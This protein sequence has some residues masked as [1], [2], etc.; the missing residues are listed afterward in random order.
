MSADNWTQCP[1]CY[2]KNMKRAN[3]LDKIAAES[4][5]KVSVDKFDEL[6]NEAFSFRKAIT[7]DE[8]I[9]ETLR[10]DYSI[11][12]QDGEFSVGYCG[13]CD[14][15]GFKFEYKHKEEVQ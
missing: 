11:G 13:R 2:E 6:R 10:E 5:G 1:R 14:T 7:S 15:C 8:N 3:E 4:Y 12:I 9:A